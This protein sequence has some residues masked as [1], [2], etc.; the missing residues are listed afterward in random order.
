MASEKIFPY[1]PAQRARCLEPLLHTIRGLH[2]TGETIIVAIQGGFGTGKTT[3]ASYLVHRLSE[4]AYR[5]VSFSIDDF[6]TRYEDRRLLAAQHPGNPYYQVPRGMPGTHRI[7]ALYDALSHFKGGQDVDLPVF[8][9]SAH[10]AQ[11]DIADRVVPVRGRQDFILVEGWCIGMPVTTAEELTD[12]CQRQRLLDISSLPA[13]AHLN[14]VLAY[15]GAY[16]QLWTLMDF[17]VMLR[18]DSPLLHEGWR[19]E[20]ERDLRAHT[21]SG[22]PEEHLRDYV[23]RFLPLTYLCYEKITPDM[24]IWINKEHSYY[25]INRRT[26]MRTPVVKRQTT[27]RSGFPNFFR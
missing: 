3:L 21:G 12:I 25:E 5:A 26:L 4:A 1:S 18:P 27:P 7:E 23:R 17:L 15:L 10:Q 13:S 6:H 16:Q 20:R 19:L 8:D 22:L 11:G 24:R 2:R 9:K 14:A